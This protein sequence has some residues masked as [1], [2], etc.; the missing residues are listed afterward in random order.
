MERILWTDHYSRCC[1]Y[2]SDKI[3]AAPALKE[4]LSNRD[5]RG[6]KAIITKQS[7]LMEDIRSCGL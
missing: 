2:H 5:G 6:E 1:K 7:T 3:N 4:V